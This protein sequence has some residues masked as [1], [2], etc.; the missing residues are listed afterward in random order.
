MKVKVLVYAAE[1]EGETF[2]GVF[3]DME[4]LKDAAWKLCIETFDMENLFF[5][6]V[7]MGACFQDSLGG[8]CSKVSELFS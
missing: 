5:Y 6:E 1:Y 2:L 8:D 3:A 4:S 7:E